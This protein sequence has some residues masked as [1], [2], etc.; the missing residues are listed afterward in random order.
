[1][2]DQSIHNTATTTS[3]I[4]RTSELM[5]SFLGDFWACQTQWKDKDWNEI[6][7]FSVFCECPVENSTHNRSFPVGLFHIMTAWLTSHTH[8][9]KYTR[10][11]WSPNVFFFFFRCAAS[12]AGHYRIG[13][14]THRG[15]YSFTNAN[16]NHFSCPGYWHCCPL[17]HLPN[18]SP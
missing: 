4:N 11:S 6:F 10:S 2:K 5:K 7:T 17:N 18:P 14:K 15:D 3:H 12:C 9:H 8:T 13:I 1:M 16:R